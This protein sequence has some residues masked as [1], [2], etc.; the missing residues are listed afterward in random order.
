MPLIWVFPF[1][2]RR[3]F[4]MLRSK[5]PFLNRRS[6]P[7]IFLFIARF[8][9]LEDMLVFMVFMVGTVVVGN[10]KTRL[11]LL[12]PET[13]HGSKSYWL[14]NCKGGWSATHRASV[15]GPS[16]TRSII[17]SGFSL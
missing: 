8:L 11:V 12:C 7:A 10:F 9:I 2:E 4:V 6:L 16:M 13:E 17:P 3:S 14:A 1:R 5:S 15:K